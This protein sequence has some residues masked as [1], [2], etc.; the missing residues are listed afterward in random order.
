MGGLGETPESQGLEQPKPWCRGPLGGMQSEA[1][2]RDEKVNDIFARDLFLIS[3]K[4]ILLIT[5]A[6]LSCQPGAF[7][8]FPENTSEVTP[9]KAPTPEFQADAGCPVTGLALPVG[10]GVAVDS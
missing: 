10:C 1:K 5:K 7:Q 4:H 2:G 8:Q 3:R 9:S 6:R